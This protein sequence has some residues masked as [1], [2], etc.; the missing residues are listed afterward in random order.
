[1]L[2]VEAAGRDRAGR[3]APLVFFDGDLAAAA[4]IIRPLRLTTGT[5]KLAALDCWREH[6]STR[7]VAIERHYEVMRVLGLELSGRGPVVPVVVRDLGP[8]LQG[9]LNLEGI[10]RLPDG[11]LLMIVD[12]HH[13]TR[14]GENQLVWLAEPPV[15]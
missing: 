1:V 13:G 7:G 10:V 14:T 4:P 12:N 2:G 11:R 6:G 15:W 5:G 8:A 3:W 9:S